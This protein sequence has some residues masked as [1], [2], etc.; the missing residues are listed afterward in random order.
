MNNNML[1]VISEH[2]PLAI[3]KL[4]T[5]THLLKIH[6]EYMQNNVPLQ[7]RYN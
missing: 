7:K 3:L 6:L 2:N 5:I 1:E 4:F